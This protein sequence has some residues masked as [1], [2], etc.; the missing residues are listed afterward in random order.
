MEFFVFHC[1]VGKIHGMEFLKHH[2]RKNRQDMGRPGLL[3]KESG[4]SAGHVEGHWRLL[5][6]YV[7]CQFQ[8]R[9]L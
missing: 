3:A 4:S 9:V 5:G 6:V 8:L 2:G 7:R 1:G